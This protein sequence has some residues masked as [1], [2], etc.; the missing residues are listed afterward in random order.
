MKKIFLLLLLSPLIANAQLKE[1]EVSELKNVSENVVQA[2]AKYPEDAIILVY[3]SLDMLQF[4]SSMGVI[5]KQTYNTTANRYEILTSPVKQMLFVMAPGYMQLKV[6]T[7]NPTPKQVYY[8]K[9]EEKLSEQLGGKGT[10][11]IDTDPVGANIVL[12]NLELAQKTPIEIPVSTGANK[13]QLRKKRY[14]ELD[15]IVKVRKDEKLIL[16][17]ILKPSWADLTITTSLSNK[18]YASGET[19][20]IYFSSADRAG[21][22]GPRIYLNGEGRVE[23]SATGTLTLT[24]LTRGLDPGNYNLR[25]SLDNYRTYEKALQ[26]K[27][28]DLVTLDVTLTP[29]TGKLNVRSTPAGAKVLIDGE[30]VGQTPYQQDLIIGEY[31]ILVAKKGHK[32]KVRKFTISDGS[33]EDFDLTL[34]N[35]GKALKPLQGAKWTFF[36][37]TLAG[38]GTGGYFLYSSISGYQAYTT[39]TENTE[40]LR[41]QVQM[42]DI[43]YPIGFAVAGSALIPTIIYRTKI[44]K[45]KKE[46]GLVA[47]P[48]DKGAVV[49]YTHNF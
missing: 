31:E 29:I 22:L 12:N 9:V 45:L 47:L 17:Q 34:R 49:C 28:A 35:Y 37:L 19:E 2:S 40:S 33:Y 46:W 30:K 23:Q 48:T 8:Y 21:T 24:G 6:G 7:I 1:F 27:A 43:V 32:E 3:T 11:V 41:K 14:Q 10:V 18:G 15:T 4:R 13:I 42:A 38:L 20:G 44:R 16:D 5:N 36:G 25:V 26:L 39:A